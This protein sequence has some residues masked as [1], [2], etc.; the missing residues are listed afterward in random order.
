VHVLTDGQ[1]VSLYTP[2]G[3]PAGVSK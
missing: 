2:P 3:T 1:K